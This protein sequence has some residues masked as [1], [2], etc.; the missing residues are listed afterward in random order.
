MKYKYREDAG[1]YISQNMEMQYNLQVKLQ[2]NLLGMKQ[3]S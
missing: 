1:I 3:F 2:Q